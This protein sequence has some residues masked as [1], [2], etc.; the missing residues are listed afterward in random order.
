MQTSVEQEMKVMK[1]H[2]MPRS[3]VMQ[4]LTCAH[5]LLISFGEVS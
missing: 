5:V 2:L 3:E 1:S 4:R